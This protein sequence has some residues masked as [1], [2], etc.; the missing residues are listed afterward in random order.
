[1]NEKIERQIRRLAYALK[2]AQAEAEAARIL[3]IQGLDD[4]PAFGT[5]TSLNDELDQRV[6]DLRELLETLG[7]APAV[8]GELPAEAGAKRSPAGWVPDQGNL[9]K[10]LALWK[11]QAKDIAHQLDQAYLRFVNI[12]GSLGLALEQLESPKGDANLAL[13]FIK[14]AQQEAK[15]R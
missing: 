13:V 6:D 3:M 8:G 14:Q 12:A 9:E 4:G 1:M 7:L 11:V 15:K 5:I 2:A 10:D